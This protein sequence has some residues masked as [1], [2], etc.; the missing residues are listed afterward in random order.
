VAKASISLIGRDE[1]TKNAEPFG[2]PAEIVCKATCS[3][4]LWSSA[5]TFD[6]SFD[7]SFQSEIQVGFS[8]ETSSFGSAKNICEAVRFVSIVEISV[9]WHCVLYIVLYKFHDHFRI[10]CYQ[11]IW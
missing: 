9:H 8:V 5:I 6:A 10:N 2:R 4:Q 11:M 1:P 7:V 3:L